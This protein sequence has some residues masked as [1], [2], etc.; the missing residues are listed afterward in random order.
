MLGI[1]YFPVE[2]G[3]KIQPGMNIQITPQTIKRE[4]FGGI[5]GDVN[6]ISS[7]P[8]TKEAAANVVGN[9][10][11]VEGLV[12]KDQPGLMQVSADLQTDDST[13]SGYKWSS[14]AGPNLKISPGTTSIARVKVDERTPI[15]YVIPLLRSV[16]GIY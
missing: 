11:V 2:D 7:F 10:E 15:S 5:V 6:K 8:I 14:S 12:S 4:R 3:K 1:T 16:S 13:F 9:P